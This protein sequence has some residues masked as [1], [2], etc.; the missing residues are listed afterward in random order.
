MFVEDGLGLGHHL[1]MRNT[2]LGRGERS[3]HLGANPRV[4]GFGV[5][6]CRE[7]GL[8]GGEFGHRGRVS[9]GREFI[10]IGGEVPSIS[11]QSGADQHSSY[12]KKISV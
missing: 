7:L 10:Q 5:F 2:R 6:S 9:G 1:I 3:L 12:I 8:D 11:D 4:M